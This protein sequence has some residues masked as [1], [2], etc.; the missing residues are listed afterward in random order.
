[1]KIMIWAIS[2]ISACISASSWAADINIKEACHQVGDASLNSLWNSTLIEA[3]RTGTTQEVYEIESRD[4]GLISPWIL[5]MG[6]RIESRLG[7]YYANLWKAQHFAQQSQFPATPIETTPN[8]IPDFSHLKNY[9]KHHSEIKIEYTDQVLK[10]FNDFFK[11]RQPVADVEQVNAAI[12]YFCSSRRI[13]GCV[14][15]TRRAL[16]IMAPTTGTY[17]YLSLISE[18]RQFFTDPTYIKPLSLTAIKIMDR[19]EQ[20]QLGVAVEGNLFQDIYSSFIESG[21]EPKEAEDRTYLTLGVYS[22]RGAGMEGLASEK[23]RTAENTPAFIPLFVISSGM[24]VLDWYKINQNSHSST[25]YSLPENVETSCLPS[26]P[27]HFWNSAY[28][29]RKVL[30]EGGH[31]K[32]ASARSMTLLGRAYSVFSR[33]YGRNPYAIYGS[34]YRSPQTNGH[35]MDT[36]FQTAGAFYG[37]GLKKIGQNKIMGDPAW[38]LMMKKGR[39]RKHYP[40][41]LI[42]YYQKNPFEHYKQWKR[43]IAPDM[44]WT[45]F[46]AT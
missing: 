34:T 11:N 10:T 23:F 43:I 13:K 2:G 45:T 40:D 8:Q 20:A 27:Y 39:M 26:K 3:A 30:T 19:I 44:V 5:S 18:M 33:T 6:P 24:N 12:P 15:A 14:A 32:S 22:T 4:S 25:Y 41:T 21:F 36:V 17:V 42:D 16:T 38:M 37:A 46:R 35:R 28:I 1:M 31:S 29:A 7:G 9:F